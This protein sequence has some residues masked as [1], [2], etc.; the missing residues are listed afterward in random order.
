MILL[1]LILAGA[2]P[3]YPNTLVPGTAST[4]TNGKYKWAGNPYCV[5]STGYNFTLQPTSPAIDKGALIPGFHCPKPGSALDQPRQND[6]YNSYCVEWYGAA[7]D[8]GACEFV[9]QPPPPV[10]TGLTVKP[11]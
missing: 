1:L 6:P 11:S 7:P 3:W 5:G 9:P 10:P 8:I 4:W 2:D